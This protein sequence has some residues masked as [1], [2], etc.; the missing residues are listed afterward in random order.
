MTLHISTFS[1]IFCPIQFFEDRSWDY[2]TTFF[3]QSFSLFPHPMYILFVF[4]SMSSLF[5]ASLQCLLQC[6]STRVLL[7]LR[8]LTIKHPPLLTLILLLVDDGNI[9]NHVHFCRS[10]P[11][12]LSLFLQLE[13]KKCSHSLFFLPIRVDW[14]L[15]GGIASTM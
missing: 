14:V 2:D 1:S 10:I 9:G 12:L 7:Q 4:W 8:H 15:R 5:L 6:R 11:T 3:L 13:F